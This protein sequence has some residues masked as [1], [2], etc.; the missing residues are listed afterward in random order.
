M[1]WITPGT[2][3]PEARARALALSSY[4]L[5]STT[6]AGM[7]AG[8]VFL[9]YVS[10]L[11]AAGAFKGMRV[12]KRKQRVPGQRDQLAIAVAAGLLVASI[13]VMLLGVALGSP[14]LTWF[15]LI[16]VLGGAADLGYWLRQPRERMHW[17]YEHMGDMLGTCI[18]ALTA[19]LVVN[20]RSLGLPRFSLLVWLLPTL[21]GVP[22]IVLWTRHYRRRFEKADGREAPAA[23]EPARPAA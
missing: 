14:L 9:L 18:A 21:V 20:A 6:R 10:L 23:L 3:A 8:A 15:P 7:Q 2:C 22:A 4:R 19:F 17:W 13:P 1:G 12:L 5:A 16:G 11:T